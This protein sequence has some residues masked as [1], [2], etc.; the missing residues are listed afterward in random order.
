MEERVEKRLKDMIIN[1]GKVKISYEDIK[2]ESEFIN[3]FGYDSLSILR[4]ISN[5]EEGFEIEFE[6]E[7]LN[8]NIV[9]K[10][11]H[12]KNYIL[13]KLKEKGKGI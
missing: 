13:K 3:E 12:L 2:E 5:I 10:Y 6:D 4:L 9:G 1:N 7:D 8:I 11:G